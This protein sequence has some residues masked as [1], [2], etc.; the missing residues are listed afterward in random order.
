[1]NFS[2]FRSNRTKAFSAVFVAAALIGLSPVQAE[3]VAVG[4][5]RA[6]VNAELADAVRSGDIAVSTSGGRFSGS[7]APFTSARAA[8]LCGSAAFDFDFFAGAG[9]G[10]PPSRRLVC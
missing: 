6:Q 7:G 1:M 10:S 5:T 8:M 9:A 3:D 2:N 4:K